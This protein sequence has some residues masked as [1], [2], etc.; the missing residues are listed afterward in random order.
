MCVFRLI[1][2]GPG[3]GG[4]PWRELLRQEL[5]GISHHNLGLF[6]GV[7]DGQI[8]IIGSVVAPCCYGRLLAPQ[9]S[10]W[11]SEASWLGGEAYLQLAKAAEGNQDEN[12]EPL[13]SADNVPPLRICVFAEPELQAGVLDAGCVPP[14]SNYQ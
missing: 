11:V 4:E 13:R 9:S 10:A 8:A 2:L 6:Q 12:G 7:P 1:G 3:L 14:N 5:K